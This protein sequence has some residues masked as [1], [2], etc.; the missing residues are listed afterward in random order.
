MICEERLTIVRVCCCFP[1][2]GDG[3]YYVE[4]DLE[5]D[6][7]VDEENMFVVEVP[8]LAT[9][10]HSVFAFL[11]FVNNGIYNGLEF[12]STHSIIQ[13]DSDEE[14]VAKLEYASSILSLAEGVSSGTCTPYSVGFVG[15][16]GALK[17]IMTSDT[18]K[19][20]NLACFGRIAQGR[21]TI[22]RIQQAAK[23]GKS[24]TVSN[25]KT[26]EMTSRPNL[27]EGEL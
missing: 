6:D 24:V 2:Y 25:V 9:L 19:H 27:G 11:T 18:S 4:F 13:L 5:L 22:S 3:P 14:H 12:L 21:R 20:G 26:I 15:S 17:I 10:P 16:N 1:R 23:H 7:D 8:T